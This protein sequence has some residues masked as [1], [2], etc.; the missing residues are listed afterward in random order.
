MT[1]TLTK[2]RATQLLM[3]LSVGRGEKEKEQLRELNAF[4][5]GLVAGLEHR[6]GW[7]YIPKVL[8]KFDPAKSRI[9]KEV[10]LQVYTPNFDIADELIEK[11]GLKPETFE[12][13]IAKQALILNAV[14]R[15][16]HAAEICERYGVSEEGLIKAVKELKRTG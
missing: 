8:E 9:I 10:G 15:H 2:D 16:T 12:S 11:S 14:T 5:T 13:E 4:M 7:D 1:N 6:Y 3:N